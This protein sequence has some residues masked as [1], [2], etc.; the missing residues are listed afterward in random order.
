MNYDFRSLRRLVG[1]Y[2]DV[3]LSFKD[4]LFLTLVGRNDW[5]S[6]LPQGKNSYFYP[7][8]T[9]SFIV[10]DVVTLPSVINNLKVR[11]GRTKVGLDA[12][13]YQTASNYE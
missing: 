7:G 12:S 1:V 9:V 10:S 5:S 2:G 3:L 8:A 6:T 13:P 4:Y 11:G